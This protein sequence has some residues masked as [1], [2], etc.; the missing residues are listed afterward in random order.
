MWYIT[1]GC[2]THY[3]KNPHGWRRMYIKLLTTLI[4]TYN[5]KIVCYEI[6][7]YVTAKTKEEEKQRDISPDFLF[8]VLMECPAYIQFNPQHHEIME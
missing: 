1:H 6:D 2:G 3:R 7:T 5:L 8:L 4:A